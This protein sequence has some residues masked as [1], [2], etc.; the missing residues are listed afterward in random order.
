MFS[1]P[2][3]YYA[4]IKIHFYPNTYLSSVQTPITSAFISINLANAFS[5][6]WTV[7]MKTI[8]I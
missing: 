1:N 8:L 2:I 4:E 5:E 6:N 3:S 7:P